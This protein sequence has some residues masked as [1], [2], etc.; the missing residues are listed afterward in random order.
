MI[1]PLEDQPRRRRRSSIPPTAGE[2]PRQHL[3]DWSGILQADAG[4]CPRAGQRPDPGGGYARLYDAG[5]QPAPIIEAG[6]WSHARRAFFVL[7][8]LEASARRKANGKKPAPISPLAIE[9]VQRMDRLFEVE[10]SINGRSPRDRLTTRR[11]LSAP[12]VDELE[13]LLRKHRPGLSRHDDL[14]KAMDYMLK[15]W[16]T[17]FLDDGRVC[18]S[19]NAAERAL[20]GIALGRKAW[21]F[22]GSDRGGQRAAFMYSLI[23]T[24]K[25]N[26]V[27][28]QA[29]L[30]DVLARIAEHSSQRLDDLL[31]WNWA[32]QHQIRK[33]A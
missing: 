10:R 3:A 12:L 8:D 16:L 5:R 19:N 21:L 4:A 30:A 31:P 25:L 23:V 9:I 33:T 2:H 15:R 7:A 6:C 22:A 11:A 24:A 14:A 32:V 18:L 28:P 13:A 1:A 17:R 27:D 20:R 26:D 29:W